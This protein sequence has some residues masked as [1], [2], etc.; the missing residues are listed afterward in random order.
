MKTTLILLLLAMST[1]ANAQ[2]SPAPGK[3][4]YVK[5]NGVNYYYEIHGKGEPVLLLHGGLGNGNM[6][7][8]GIPELSESRTVIAV[9][10]YGHGRTA[11]TD[12]AI[13]LIDIGDDMAPLIQQLGYSR[14]DAMGYSFG[15]GVA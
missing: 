7:A 2:T 5:A 12:R 8:P 14:V 4:G 10:L 9:D 6:F 11:L 13:S 15:G 3:T 1:A